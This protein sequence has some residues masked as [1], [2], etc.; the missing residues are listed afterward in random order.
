MKN[1]SFLSSPRFTTTD[2]LIIGGG[3]AGCMLAWK[4]KQ[5][6]RQCILIDTPH[7]SNASRISAG[8]INPITGKRFSPFW[9]NEAVLSSALQ[10]YKSLEQQFNTKFLREITA[11]RLFT[12]TEER[13]QW[14]AKRASALTFAEYLPPESI[15][16]YIHQQ[17]GGIRYGA[18]HLDA[19][20]LIRSLR[21]WLASEGCVR[22]EEYHHAHTDF[23]GE[24]VVIKTTQEH[25]QTRRIVFANGWKVLETEHWG[26]LPL[27]PA[28]GEL[29]TVRAK[30]VPKEMLVKGVF[31][32]PL[33]DSTMRIGAS[34]SWE[35]LN[36]VPTPNTAETLI[37]QAQSVFPTEMTLLRHDA[38]V[39]PAAQDSKPILGIHP[40]EPRSVI[41]NGFGSKGA[42]YTPYCAEAL[43]DFLEEEKPLASWCALS[44]WRAWRL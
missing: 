32:L 36:D 25:L 42:V 24:H 7:K 29:L 13:E 35:E 30:R 31:M 18:W 43:I 41:F 40:E 6:G 11:L 19:E 38:G 9:D 14:F 5:S 10:S 17:W 8:I 21:A 23:S 20:L 1:I 33:D 34:Y 39:R 28:K 22:N 12:D 44:R 26:N 37:A 2:Y 16:S 15:H 27:S 4:L 3:L